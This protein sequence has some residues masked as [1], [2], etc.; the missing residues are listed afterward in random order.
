V[1]DYGN[2]ALQEVAIAQAKG[3]IIISIFKS[4][5]SKSPEVF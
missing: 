3:N 2:S 1:A 5:F 4:R